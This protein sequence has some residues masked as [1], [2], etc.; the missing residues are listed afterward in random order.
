MR[1]CGRCGGESG[2]STMSYFDTTII[3]IPCDNA[4]RAHPMYQ[5]AKDV[6]LKALQSGD[7]NYP[8]IGLPEDLRR[9]YE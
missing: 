3:C 9:K 5:E 1:T 2:I 4:E 8:G 6:E 7:Y